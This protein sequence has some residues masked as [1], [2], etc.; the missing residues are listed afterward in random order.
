MTW[1]RIIT[2]V[3]MVPIGAWLVF[4]N[5]FNG[6][7][8]FIGMLIIAIIIAYEIA[9]IFEKN[10]F[11]FNLWLH[12]FV[13]TVSFISFYLFGTGAIDAGRLFVVQIGIITVYMLIIICTESI[14]GR[15]DRS[16][17]NIAF[18]AFSYIML[19]IYCP[20]AGLLK[21]MDMSG[22]LLAM[23]LIITFFTDTGGWLFGKLFGRHRVNFLSSPNKTLEGFFGA[24]L[25]GCTGGALIY[26]LGLIYPL[27]SRFT[28]SEIVLLTFAVIISA[29]IGDLGESCIKRWAHLKDSGDLLPG[30]G[31][32]FDR[33][34]SFIFSTPVFFVIVKLLGR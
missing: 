2:V 16:V 27:P 4:S 7:F 30:H 20:I 29:I 6:L 25:L 13:I 5:L 31:G 11:S 33:F 21:M 34:D 12:T 28:L 10:G 8:V 1:N 9:S 18:P 32:F 15:F 17:E 26:F 14:S 22:W 3:L 24:L 19:G 23:L